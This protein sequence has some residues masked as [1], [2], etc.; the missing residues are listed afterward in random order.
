MTNPLKYLYTHNSDIFQL[1]HEMTWQHKIA[2]FCL[3]HLF[4]NCNLSKVFG[5]DVHLELYYDWIY[6]QTCLGFKALSPLNSCSNGVL[7]MSISSF[8][9]YIGRGNLLLMQIRL[10]FIG[11]KPSGSSKI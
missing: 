11:R 10:S 6:F 8:E 1:K 7:E 3:T 4:N 9:C 5:S 2:F